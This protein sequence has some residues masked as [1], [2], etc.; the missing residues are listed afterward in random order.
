MSSSSKFF[1]MLSSIVRI[2]VQG[3]TSDKKKQVV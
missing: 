3:V 1:F 2:G